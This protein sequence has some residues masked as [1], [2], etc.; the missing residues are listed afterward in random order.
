MEVVRKSD[1]SRGNKVIITGIRRED[2]FL[3]K[4]YSRTPYHLVELIENI[5]DDGSLTVNPR[6]EEDE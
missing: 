1:F 6:A 3:G 2:M 5:N 4:K